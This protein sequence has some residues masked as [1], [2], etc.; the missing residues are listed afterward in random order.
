MIRRETIFEPHE[1]SREALLVVHTQRYLNSLNVS[2]DVFTLTATA[3]YCQNDRVMK[4]IAFKLQYG[5]LGLGLN[6]TYGSISC[7]YCI[8]IVLCISNGSKLRPATDCLC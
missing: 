3:C 8:N 5:F 6:S 2:C 7:L 1:I 4:G